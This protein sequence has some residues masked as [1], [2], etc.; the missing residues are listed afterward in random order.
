M[1]NR[2]KILAN[3]RKNR[4][5]EAAHPEIPH[6]RVAGDMYDNFKKHVEGFDGKVFTF[7]SRNEALQ[8]LSNNVKG[9]HTFSNLPDWHGNILPS[10]L[11]SPGDAHLL[12]NCVAEGFMGIGETGSVAVDSMSL[13]Q[14]ANGLLALNLYLLLDREKMVDGLQT[15]YNTLDLTQYQYMAFFSGPSATADIEAVHI[16]GAQ[17]PLSLTVLLYGS[18]REM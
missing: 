12:D 11:T 1:D 17:G 10:M 7:V 13:G 8:W 18:P 15:A 2:D 5:D 6:F 9:E 3:L 16:T 4:P 14:A